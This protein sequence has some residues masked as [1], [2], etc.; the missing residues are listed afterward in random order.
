[1]RKGDK[2]LT[3]L[4]FVVFTVLGCNP[5]VGAY[6]HMQEEIKV[7]VDLDAVVVIGVVVCIRRK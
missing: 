4:L 2:L 5:L 7:F 1:M 6:T 3:P